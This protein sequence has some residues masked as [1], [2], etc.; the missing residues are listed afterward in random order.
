MSAILEMLTSQLGGKALD[1]ISQQLGTDR[2]TTENAVP[3]ALATLLGGLARNSASSQG[4]VLD[5]LAII[6]ED[7]RDLDQIVS[8]EKVQGFVRSAT[9]WCCGAD[10]HGLIHRLDK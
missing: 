6:K 9:V 10:R 2:P 4:A 7:I 1:Q 3:A 5:L 8:V